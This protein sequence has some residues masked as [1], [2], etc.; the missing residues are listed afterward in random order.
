MYFVSDAM[1][2]EPFTVAPEDTTERANALMHNGRL[3]HLPVM[4]KGLLV[5]LVTQHDLLRTPPG[6]VSDRMVQDVV[7]ATARM[8]L[9]RAARL[10]FEGKIG[11]LPV[12]DD[13][14][15]V[16]GILTEADFIRFAADLATDFDRI[17]A[18]AKRFAGGASRD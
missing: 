4:S 7:T 2:P 15:A 6:L 10:M 1:T 5:G 11:C 13:N 9:R 17:E 8:P 12:V 3:R 14:R 16:V 18:T